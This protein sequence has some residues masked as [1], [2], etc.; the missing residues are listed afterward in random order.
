MTRVYDRAPKIWF[1]EEQ[2]YHHCLREGSLSSGGFSW[3]KIQSIDGG[4][5]YQKMLR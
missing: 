5:D 2:L 3:S 1:S 4:R